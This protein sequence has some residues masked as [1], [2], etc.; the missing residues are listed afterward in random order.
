[1]R[2]HPNKIKEIKKKSKPWR[3][4]YSNPNTFLYVSVK[5]SNNSH[6]NSLYG[7]L[8]DL[9]RETTSGVTRTL[10]LFDV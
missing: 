9:M 6:N 10:F 8:S 7:V 3:G 2:C 4:G 5:K 1:M